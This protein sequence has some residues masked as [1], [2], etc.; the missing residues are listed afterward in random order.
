MRQHKT[1][2]WWRALALALAGAG[3]VAQA[4]VT[5]IN[6]NSDPAAASLYRELGNGAA[7]WRASGG[8]SGGA[9]DGYLA[10]ND[11]KGGQQ[12]TLVFKDLES[13]LV[14]KAF[15][16]EVDLRI[17]GGTGQPA[18]GFSINYVRGGDELLSNADQGIDPSYLNFAGADGAA[19]L[20]EEG[21]RTGLG[22]G[23]DT[24]QSGGAGA[25]HPG[26][27]TDVVGISVRV[28]GALIT[29]L[30]VPL[31]PGNTFPGGTYD[32]APYRNLPAASANYASSM[33]TGALSDVD[34][35]DDGVVDGGDANTPQP[36]LADVGA[37]VWGKWI[38]NLRWEKFV[39]ELTEDS[40]VK[41]SW[42]GVELT[43]AGG[44][45]VDFGPS[46]GRIVFAGRTGGAWE[47]HH[48]DNIVLTTVAS[49]KIVVGTAA[50]NP[51]GFTLG[52]EDSGASVLNPSSVVLKLNG[53]AVDG[54]KVTTAK[55][56]ATT[57][58]NYR[59][60]AALLPIGSTNT[61][62]VTARDTRNLAVTATRTF[63]VAPYT[64]LGSDLAVPSANLSQPGFA[65]RVNQIATG[66]G[67]DIL[68]AERQLHGDLGENISFEPTS[69]ETTTI[70]Y[71][72]D[73]P[74]NAG[75]FNAGNGAEDRAIPG[76]DT[77]T[78]SDNIAMEIQTVLEFNEAGVYTLIFNSDDGFRTTFGKNSREQITGLIASQFDGGRGASDTAVTLV[79]PTPGFFPVRS[80]WFEG[81]GGANLEWVVIRDGKPRALVNDGTP[82]SVR[83]FRSSTAAVPPGVVFAYPARQ[84]GNPYL[85]DLPITLDIADGSAATVNGGSIVLKVNDTTVTPTISK[86]GTTTTVRYAAPGQFPSGTTNKIDLAFTDSA[87]G[88][89]AGTYTYNVASYTTIPVSFRLP[90]SA[91][92]ATK[93]G[94]IFKPIQTDQGLENR[95]RRADLHTRGLYGLPNYADLSAAD[96]T[97]SFVITDVINFDQGPGNA[98]AFNGNNGFPEVGIPGI[99]GTV[100]PNGNTSTDNISAEIL[101]VVE[102]PTAGLYTFSFN[103]DDGFGTWF[104]HPKDQARMLVGQFDGG[105]GASDTFY[106]VLITQPGLY[107]VRSVWFEGGGGANLEWYT[108][109]NGVSA[110]LNDSANGGLKTYQYT[111]ATG[112][113]WVKKLTPANGANRVSLNDPIVAVIADGTGSVTPAS[114]SMKLNGVAVPATVNKSGTETTVSYKPSLV[115]GSTNTVEIAFGDR[116]ITSSFTA[117]DL[118]SVAFFI[119]AEDFNHSSGQS[120]AAASDMANYRGGAYGGKAAVAGVDYNRGNEGASPLY[121]IGEDPQVP[122]D[123][124]YSEAWGRGFTDLEVNF[125]IGWI[126]AGQWYNYTRT[127]PAGK[128]NVYAGLSHG[129]SL[130]GQLSGSLQKVT[131]GANTANQTLEELGTFTGQ[132]TGGWGVNRLV[133]LQNAG[134]E[135]VALDLGGVTTL[136]YSTT[137]GDFDFLILTP[138][139]TE[140]P[141][142]TKTTLNANGTLTLEWTGGGT[143][144]AGPSINGPWAPMAG[145]TS[146]YTFTPDPAV[147]QLYGRIVR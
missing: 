89:Y 133:P 63:V 26:G 123:V 126:G 99:P 13:G 101:T 57:S 22:I 42:K 95:V 140:R 92:D 102:F 32:E 53:A 28:D 20:P 43:P 41:I 115:A 145:A 21:S 116:T 45:S 138:A 61:V 11:A 44:L 74:A 142:F 16:F 128:Y 18:D 56:G 19:S 8:A 62:E 59:N 54:S 31:R 104:G 36:V 47:A 12:A 124:N 6:F 75:N 9:T 68:R 50:S 137:N 91:V 1:C 24:W 79:V 29:Q 106:S 33:Q 10:L 105:R 34:L 15:K 100:L 46:S 40:K 81:G 111:G 35:N 136:R 76:V 135:N 37:E 69:V 143:L 51:I 93:P 80:V 86:A 98:G 14:V 66:Q 94:F 146:P 7:E 96:T 141:M 48:I 132:G 55:T 58:I 134:G 52:I 103:S 39:A 131:A 5:T 147:G 97:G 49:D 67:N 110:L 117:G 85:A 4:G 27:I 70:N 108:R 129:E 125:K 23:Y 77:V 121:R 139:P 90:A 144:Q 72:Q 109:K 65:L 82:N 3:S 122:M 84:T 88:S 83:A 127:I 114:V 113:T 120:E 17:G 71:N 78:N 2:Q 60:L 87:G 130:A 107:P 112:P 118:P 25:G 64:V 38:K 30:P 119:E 73:A